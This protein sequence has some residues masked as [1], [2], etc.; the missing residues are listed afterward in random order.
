MK[1]KLPK[2]NY[3]LSDGTEANVAADGWVSLRDS[4]LGGPVCELTDVEF[5]MLVK[6]YHA[7]AEPV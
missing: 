4:K 6:T 7:K 1:M 5:D 2:G 3:S